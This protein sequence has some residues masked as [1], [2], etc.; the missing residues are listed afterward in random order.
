M[1]KC[2]LVSLA[3][4][5]ILSL[6]A[7]SGLGDMAGTAPAVTADEASAKQVCISNRQMIVNTLDSLITG[8]ATGT[9]VTKP[10][11]FTVSFDGSTASVGNVTGIDTL[12]VQSLF[13]ILP[14]CPDKG[15]ITVSV[16]FDDSGNDRMSVTCSIAAH[17]A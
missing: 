3:V 4:A 16:T 14:Y 2:F 11:E 1:K 13:A 17:N 10:F 6:C 8:A 12:T 15:V 5:L 7:C 9:P